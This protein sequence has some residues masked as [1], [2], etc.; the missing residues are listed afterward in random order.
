[1]RTRVAYV[2]ALP[3][4]NEQV[5]EGKA[6][7]DKIRAEIAAKKGEKPKVSHVYLCFYS[8]VVLL[9]ATKAGFDEVSF[10]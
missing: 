4:V 6:K 1:M 3:H 2:S 8:R 7:K 10:V 5:E 9:L